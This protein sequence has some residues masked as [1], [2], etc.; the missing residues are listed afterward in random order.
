MISYKK[1]KKN[2]KNIKKIR[3]KK[4]LYKR[5]KNVLQKIMNRNKKSYKEYNK[6]FYINKILIINKQQ[7]LIIYYLSKNLNKDKKINQD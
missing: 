3:K 5:N 2:N 7:Q 4:C 6:D 1:K